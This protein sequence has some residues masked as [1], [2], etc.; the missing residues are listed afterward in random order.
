M[1]H[2]LG[3]HYTTLGHNFSVTTSAPV[4][5]CILAND[6]LQRLFCHSWHQITLHVA[7]EKSL[8]ALFIIIIITLPFSRFTLVNKM[9]SK[10]PRKQ[11]FGRGLYTASRKICISYIPIVAG[12]S[13]WTSG[14]LILTQLEHTVLSVSYSLEN[15]CQIFLSDRGIKSCD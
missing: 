2:A 7:L 5:I 4:N 13:P 12:L 15:T 11:V 10:F 9:P 6:R 14:I 8:L 1:I 3:Q